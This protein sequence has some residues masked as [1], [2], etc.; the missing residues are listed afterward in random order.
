MGRNGAFY[1]RKAGS[2]KKA[3]GCYEEAQHVELLLRSV[4]KRFQFRIQVHG[5]GSP[6][7]SFLISLSEIGKKHRPN[8]FL[9]PML[10]TLPV[11]QTPNSH[12]QPSFLTQTWVSL[13][14]SQHQLEKFSTQQFNKLKSVLQNLRI[15][16]LA[17][18]S[19]PSHD[20]S[21]S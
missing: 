19:G 13:L 11:C 12:T 15:K 2:S 8:A 20:A 3:K 7:L 9:I 21:R 4:L 16:P 14:G 10:L 18:T 1:A 5:R 6:N 17:L